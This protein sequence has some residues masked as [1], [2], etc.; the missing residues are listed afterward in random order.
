M[1]GLSPR[2][3]AAPAGMMGTEGAIGLDP[4]SYVVA[5][6]LVPSGTI[7]QPIEIME[8]TKGSEPST[9]TLARFR[10]SIRFAMFGKGGSKPLDP[11]KGGTALEPGYK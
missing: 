2:H 8:R 11:A 1:A 4:G 6:N 3:G 7:P 5:R 10:S 9:P